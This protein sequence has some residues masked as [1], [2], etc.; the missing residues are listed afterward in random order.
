MSGPFY[1]YLVRVFVQLDCFLGA[2]FGGPE[3][4]SISLDA[5]RARLEGKPW[6][7]W[8]CKWLHH[9]LR[10]NH[11]QRTLE[12]QPTSG[13]AAVLAAVQLTVLALLLAWGPLLLLWWIL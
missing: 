1:N 8:L 6:G 11:C 5:A 3:D 4:T 7:C 2:L 9:S 12:S 13:R 10:T